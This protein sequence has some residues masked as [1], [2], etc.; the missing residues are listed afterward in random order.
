MNK[1]HDEVAKELDLIKKLDDRY[2]PKHKK[3]ETTK[4]S[5]NTTK[6]FG[7]LILAVAI[8]FIVLSTDIDEFQPI[9]DFVFGEEPAESPEPLSPA[10]LELYRFSD[11]S[12][13]TS[14][15]VELWLINL[16]ETTVKD[17]EIYIRVRNQNGTILLSD[18]IS[19]TVLIL[20]YNETCSAIYTIPISEDDNYILH[21]IEIGWTSGRTAYS[22]KTSL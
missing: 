7:I 22:K 16:G 21:T 9:Q 20:R 14:V 11:L 6:I 1:E 12:S 15:N 3:T 2:E 19:P 13:N 17:I 8:I 5:N 10:E 4:K 18:E